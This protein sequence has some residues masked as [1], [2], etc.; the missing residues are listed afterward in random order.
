MVWGLNLTPALDTCGVLI[1]EWLEDRRIWQCSPNASGVLAQG[2][3][4]VPAVLT[5]VSE[6]SLR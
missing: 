5:K 6:F 4:G 3:R 1:E 2:W